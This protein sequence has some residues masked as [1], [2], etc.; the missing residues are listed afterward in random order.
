MYS[1]GG[2]RNQVIETGGTIDIIKNSKSIVMFV[3]QSYHQFIELISDVVKET[4]NCFQKKMKYY[5]A[6]L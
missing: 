2:F 6:I 5:Y 1:E 4:N 3:S